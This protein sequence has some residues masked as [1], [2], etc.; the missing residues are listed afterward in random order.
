MKLYIPICLLCI[1]SLG[2]DRAPTAPIPPGA[3]LI[4]TGIF[5]KT[6]ILEDIVI[7]GTNE[8]QFARDEL[9]GDFSSLV[10]RELEFGCGGCGYGD[11]VFL[12]EKLETGSRDEQWRAARALWRSHSRR[13]TAKVLEMIADCECPTPEYAEF[14]RECD[15]DLEPT[16]ILTELRTGDYKWGTWLATLRPNPALVPELLIGLQSKPDDLHATMLALGHSRDPR[17]LQPLL[18]ILQQ[19]DEVN[20]GFA[21]SALGH[22]GMREAE[23][24]IL[25]LLPQS[26]ESRGRLVI[27]LGEIGTRQ[28]LPVFEEITASPSYAEIPRLQVI[29]QRIIERIKAR[30][31]VAN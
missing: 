18:Q 31:P 11:E 4:G 28:S 29:I 5:S 8:E 6:Y 22:L 20:A 3:R 17:A 14:R 19:P 7:G 23:V 9:D 24:P 25:K 30:D 12:A 2:C 1:V 16:S 15:E 13:R 27:A 21:A 26:N 10:P